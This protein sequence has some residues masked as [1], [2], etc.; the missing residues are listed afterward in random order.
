MRSGN[1]VLKDSTFQQ[2]FEHVGE[3]MTL[4]GTVN[5]TAMLLAMT[6]ITAAY[7]WGRFMEAG[8]PSAIYGLLLIG[9]VGG[10][11]AALVTVFKKTAAPYSA[12]AYALFEGLFLGGISATL[13]V[14][15]P[16]SSS[17]QSVSPSARSSV[18]LRR[19]AAGSSR[20]PRTSSSAWSPPP[21]ASSCST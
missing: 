17:R 5:K 2:P 8:D 7:T 11:I 9:V 15:F 14:Q 21:A 6:L 3:R 18:C 19:I 12:P 1:P 20:P 16:G 10:L 4:S 13:E